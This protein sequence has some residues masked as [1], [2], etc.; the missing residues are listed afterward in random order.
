MKSGCT[1]L[2]LVVLACRPSQQT[3]ARAP[4]DASAD[5]TDSKALLAEVDRLKDQLRDRP[6]SFEVLS[7]LGNLYYENGRYLE[8]IDS[9]RQAL[10]ISAPVEAEAESLRKR[11]ITPAR[12]LP[13]ECRR[14]G[15]DYGL[16]Q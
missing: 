4:A 15:A 1:A 16:T 10:E 7:A 8:A 5:S 13:P 9:L 3:A 14:A 2:L 6:K 11:G 12:D